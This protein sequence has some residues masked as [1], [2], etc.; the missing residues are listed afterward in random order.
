MVNYSVQYAV[1][2][3]VVVVLFLIGFNV[4]STVL[5]LYNGDQLALAI[6]GDI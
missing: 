1:L 3:R 4:L 2:S 5:W 6:P